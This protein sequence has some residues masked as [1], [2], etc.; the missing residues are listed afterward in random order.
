MKLEFN[1]IFRLNSEIINRSQ[2][3]YVISITL[4]ILYDSVTFTIWN[5]SN[6]L[7]L[8][9]EFT[10]WCIAILMI[11][12]NKHLNLSWVQLTEI[13]EWNDERRIVN[14]CRFVLCIKKT[15]E[16]SRMF[17]CATGEP[18]F[19]LVYIHLC[20]TSNSNDKDWAKSKTECSMCIVHSIPV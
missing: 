6:S 3:F 7:I 13:V 9:A 17:I 1:S 2:I 19:F 15:L 8:K 5:I 16:T 12:K 14:I 11:M 18:P 10:V 4:Q 20:W